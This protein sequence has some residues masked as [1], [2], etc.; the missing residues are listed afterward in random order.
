M[1]TL[2]AIF[3]GLLLSASMQ[4]VAGGSL[5]LSLSNDT[6]R[7][8]YDATKVGSGLHVTGSIQHHEDDGDLLALG[9]HVV[10]VRNPNSPLYIG[11]GGKLFGFKNDDLDGVALGVGGFLSYQIP[12]LPGLSTAGYFY[13]AP[14]VVAFGDTENLMDADVRIQYSLI[15]TARVYVGYRYSKFEIEDVKEKFVLDE[16]FHLGLKVDF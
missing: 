1:K 9:M 8:E 6:A 16:G 13:Y 3:S 11:V 5:D 7:L 15:P 14:K 10:D 12:R 2:N 4:A